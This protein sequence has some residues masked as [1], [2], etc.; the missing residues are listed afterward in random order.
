MSNNTL[1]Y[2]VRTGT[3]PLAPMNIERRALRDDDVQIDIAYCGVCHTDL[4]QAHNDWKN[5]AY[6][7]VPGHEIVGRVSA[8]GARVD[9]HRLGDWVAVGCL[10]DS[11]L[12]CSACD[13]GEQQHCEKGA[14]ATYNGR[15]RQTGEV[16]MGGYSERIVVRERFV[17]R[18]PPGLDP[19]HAAP[20]LCAGVT[21]WAP[22][23]RYDAGPG[24]RV[25]V[26]G[27]GGLGHMG[28]KLAAALGAEVTMVTTSPAKADDARALGAHHVL[29]STD[30]AAMKQAASRFD[31]IID[32][33][34][35]AHDLTPYLG[36]LGRRGVL[37]V[38]GAIEPL[39]PVHGGLLVRNDRAL[40]GS[41]IGGLVATQELL[42][43]CAEHQVMPVIE[44]IAMPDINEAWQRMQANQVKYRFVI[45]M[46]TLRQP[47]G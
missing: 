15:D 9:D 43:F 1:A 24:K 6:P 30:A 47:A 8:V 32:T 7:C 12:G 22:L 33:I 27:L 42:D 39:P 29:I 25:A 18:L 35:T 19:Q 41:A 40:A 4:H 46:G 5:T 20:L 38:V 26:V 21:M 45:D 17:L 3:D 36:M 23:R 13:A 44:T 14:T 10:V 31:L 37:V 34:P 28:V 11:C 16:T 2:G